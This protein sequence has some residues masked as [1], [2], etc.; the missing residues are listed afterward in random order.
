M[1][2][3]GPRA[4]IDDFV[5]SAKRYRIWAY[6]GLQNIISR[7]RG[8]FL[9]PIWISVGTLT[10]GLAITLVFGGL[11]G[12]PIREVLPFI[13]GGITVFYFFI[14]PL[15]EA[16]GLFTG[17]AGWIKARP[18]GLMTYVFMSLTTTVIT[19]AHTIVAFFIL[20]A[21]LGIFTLPHWTFLP[22]MALILVYMTFAGTL[23]GMLGARYR[24]IGF[25]LPYIGQIFFFLTP[26]FWN[27]ATVQGPRR[28]VLDY[29]PFYYMLNLTRGPLLGSA[30]R[31]SDW[32]ATAGFT[33]VVILLW[34]LFFG[35]FRRRIIFWLN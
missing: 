12:Q 5:E 15:T 3:D 29:N 26:I 6:F 1:Q 35:A 17:S 16:P 32:I 28:I 33:G 20:L 7:Y 4:A 23:T 13:M 18:F 34:L 27:P 25:L 21:V 30:P 31:A 14:V 19:F 24:D 9:G 10:T 8:S 22:A 11:F 2:V